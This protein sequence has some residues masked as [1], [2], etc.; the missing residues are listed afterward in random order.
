MDGLVLAAGAVVA[1]EALAEARAVVA[2]ATAGAVAT[3]GVAVA[4]EHIRTRWALLERAVRAAEAEVA[5][6]A[7]VLHRVPRRGVRLVR[8]RRQLL[9]RVADATAVAV[10]GAHGTL[11]R[12]AVV[13]V[14]AVALARLA[15]AHAL[16][17]ALHPRVGLVRADRDGH[18]RRALRARAL[19]AIVLGPRHVAVRAGVAAA[20]VVH[21]ARAVARAP[22]RAVRRDER[23]EGD[24][25]KRAELHG[26]LEHFRC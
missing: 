20:L 22:V 8:L 23:R 2:D 26:V 13:V 3:L 12:D 10:V 14:K 4:A 16:V 9:L 21:A 19:R 11:A 25:E 24:E 7:H 1:D 6:A 5:D 17:R 18:P 15:V